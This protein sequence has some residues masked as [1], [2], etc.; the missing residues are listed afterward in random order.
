MLNTHE[1]F[2]IINNAWL[3]IAK[4]KVNFQKIKFEQF[5]SVLITQCPYKLQRRQYTLR[6]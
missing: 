2:T 6:L 4:M 5:F 3:P 1:L